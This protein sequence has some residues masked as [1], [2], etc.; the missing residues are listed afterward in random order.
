MGQPTQQQDETE[1]RKKKKNTTY[2]KNFQPSKTPNLKTPKTQPTT[3]KI[4]KKTNPTTK[5]H[6]TPKKKIKKKNTTKVTTP[7]TQPTQTSPKNPHPP[8][9]QTTKKHPYNL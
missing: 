2:T 4:F 5:N 6:T 1:T 9:L 7:N 8:L 3:K